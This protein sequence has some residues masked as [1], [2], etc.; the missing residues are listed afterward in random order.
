MN[1]LK[2]SRFFFIVL[3]LVLPLAGCG[4]AETPVAREPAG[5]QDINPGDQSVIQPP[6]RQAEQGSQLEER[7]I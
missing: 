2:M 6:A 4:A 3:P 7:N 1:F 5:V